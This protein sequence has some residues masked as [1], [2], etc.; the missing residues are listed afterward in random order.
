[1]VLDRLDEA[2]IGYSNIEVPALRA[3][4]R[5]YLDLQAYDHIKLKLF[6]RN[7]LYRKII[8]GGFVNLTHI[9]AKRVQII[10]HPEDLHALLCR[11]IRECPDFLQCLGFSEETKD[12]ELFSTVFPPQVDVGEK[13]SSA[14]N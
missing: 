9:N 1:M 6:V 2:F 7:D 10:W 12:E 13:K 11:R 3:L 14:W 5:T 4:F 8:R